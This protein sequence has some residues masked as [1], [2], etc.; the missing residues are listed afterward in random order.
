MKIT[1]R[2]STESA[3]PLRSWDAYEKGF[4]NNFAQFRKKVSSKNA[5]KK[6]QKFPNTEILY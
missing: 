5:N 3:K 1:L 2:V 4:K 6:K